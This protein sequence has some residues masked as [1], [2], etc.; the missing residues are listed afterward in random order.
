[1]RYAAELAA[2]I[3][4]LVAPLKKQQAE[5]QTAFAAKV[6]EQGLAKLPGEIREDV[7]V[8]LGVAP[9]KR[10][11]VQKYLA[12]KFEPELKPA[13]P[14]LAKPQ[15]AGADARHLVGKLYRGAEI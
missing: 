10:N 15:R 13:G 12:A 2:R 14:V 11:E 3:D 4:A 7:K 9:A 8:A 6:F 1:M 5:L